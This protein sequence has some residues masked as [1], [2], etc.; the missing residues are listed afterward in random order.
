VDMFDVR[1]SASVKVHEVASRV[2]H[3]LHRS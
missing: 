1:V 3:F 2:V